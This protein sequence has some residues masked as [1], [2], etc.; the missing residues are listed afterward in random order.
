METIQKIKKL[1]LCQMPGSACNLRCEYCY[2]TNQNMWNS[3][4]RKLDHS[5]LEIA[6][7]LSVKRMGGICLINFCGE[8]E[9]LLSEEALEL[10]YEWAKDGHYIEIV[11]NGTL[12]K[13]F[14]TISKYPMEILSHI[15]FKFSFHYAELKRLNLLEVFFDN[16]YLMH[17]AGCS[18]T[19]EMTPYDGIDDCKEEIL[20]VCEEKIGAPCHLTIVRDDTQMGIP[21][22]SDKSLEDYYNFWSDFGSSMFDFKKSIYGIKRKEFCYA[23]LLS[24]NI[25][26]ANGNYSKCYGCAPVGN[27]FEDMSKPIDSSAIG[28]CAVAHCYNGHAHLALGLIPNLSTPTYSKICNIRLKDGT[29][30]LS[31]EFKQIYSQ[32]VP[33]N[34]QL[35]TV[36]EEKAIYRR[37]AFEEMRV[38]GKANLKRLVK[39]V[40]GL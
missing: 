27:I 18:F 28:K 37:A 33:D 10:V 24:L 4:I 19:I 7:A 23:G 38:K 14:E 8:G 32:K 17:E 39:K 1:L 22:M 35:L 13:R 30:S 29:D 11:T 16:I 21:V 40:L 34:N 20:A 12:K 9:T 31:E 3:E 36:K 2:I 26:L 25:N 6:E 15:A 5:P